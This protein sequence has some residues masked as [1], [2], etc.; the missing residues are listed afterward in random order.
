MVAGGSGFNG[1]EVFEA[2]VDA[3]HD[4]AVVDLNCW[5]FR[6][7]VTLVDPDVSDAGRLIG[8]CARANTVVYV[9]SMAAEPA[10]LGLGIVE[11][12]V[13]RTREPTQCSA[14]HNP[15]SDAST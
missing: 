12:S 9:A 10:P 1:A 3:G 13:E 4:V 2:F 6:R 7:D 8:A 5:P 15:K 14:I 11:L